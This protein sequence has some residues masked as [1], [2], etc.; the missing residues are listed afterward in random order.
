MKKFNYVKKM[1]KNIYRY[2][3][4]LNNIGNAYKKEGQFDNAQEYYLKSLNILKK[5]FG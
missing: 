1:N 3:N 4:M 2:G 5:V